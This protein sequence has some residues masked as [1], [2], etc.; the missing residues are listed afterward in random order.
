MDFFFIP[1][2]SF[3]PRLI[4][5]EADDAM[6]TIGKQ[7]AVG[8]MTQM[9]RRPAYFHCVVEA[10]DQADQPG[11]VAFQQRGVVEHYPQTSAMASGEKNRY[12]CWVPP[13][14]VDEILAAGNAKTRAVAQETVRM[15]D[16]AMGLLYFKS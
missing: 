7:P 13:S 12:Q 3:A 14:L 8:K 5:M 4:G 15:M 6:D 2:D 16:E 9:V 1:V 10:A 11:R